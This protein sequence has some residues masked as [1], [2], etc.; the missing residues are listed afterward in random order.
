MLGNPKD[1]SRKT[2]NAFF[3]RLGAKYKDLIYNSSIDVYGDIRCGLAHAY[4][5]GGRDS[6]I[7]IGWPA[8]NRL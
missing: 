7:N 8:W 6:A 3:K 1:G 5:I 2:F 4:I